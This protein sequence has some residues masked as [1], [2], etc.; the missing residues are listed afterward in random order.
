MAGYCDGRRPNTVKIGVDLDNTII[1][2]DP[3]FH[4][5]ALEKGLVPKE[6]PADK[7]QVR[8]Y[9]RRAGK[10]SVWTELQGYVYGKLLLEADAFPGVKEFFAACRERNI[11]VVIISHKHQTPAAGP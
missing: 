7:R 10:E 2:C 1:C 3:L 11:P 6:L 9:L 5:A 8:D 4:R